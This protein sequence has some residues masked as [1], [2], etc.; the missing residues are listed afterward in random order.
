MK[1]FLFLAF[2]SVYLLS[3]SFLNI[4]PP[5]TVYPICD[6]Q[7]FK[8]PRNLRTALHARLNHQPN[9]TIE[10]LDCL[11]IS[12]SGQFSEETFMATIDSLSISLKK[13]I[14]LD[15][16]QESHGFINGI[17]ISWTDG[18]NYANIHKTK[19]EIEFDECQ[20]LR[21]AM[22]AQHIVVDP[23][24]IP[25]KLVAYIAKTERELV[26]D[27]G[28]TYIRLPVTDHKRPTDDII[29]QF[30]ALIN[31]LPSDAWIHMHCKG[32]RGRT[33]TF[34]TLYDIA[35]NARYVN[36]TDILAR[37]HLIGGVDLTEIN[38]KNEERS[39]FAKERL[40]FIQ[41]FYCYCQQVPDFQISWSEWLDRQHLIFAQSP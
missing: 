34:L 39:Q 17:P 38:K 28:A 7:E 8:L 25:N 29:D 2:L 18:N 21:L 23:L 15:L 41:Q 5:A 26:E 36:L 1:Y 14:V 33:T 27:Y 30:I 32:G 37:Q 16:R 12:G 3:Q 35:K 13:L 31:N 10:G 4:S 11:R 40:E 24:K 6:S 20:R 9:L 19:S 22:Q